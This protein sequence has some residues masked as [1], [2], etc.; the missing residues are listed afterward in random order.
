M[1]VSFLKKSIVWLL[2]VIAVFSFTACGKGEYDDGLVAVPL[3]ASDMKDRQYEDVVT[4]F[5]N[6]GFQNVHTSPMNDLIIGV[7]NKNGA[8]EEV[9]IDGKNNFRKNSRYEPDAYVVIKYHSFDEEESFVQDEESG[10]P[11]IADTSDGKISIPISSEDVGNLSVTDIVNIF[12]DAGFVDVTPQPM[13]DLIIGLVHGDGEVEEVSVDG[14]IVFNKG[15]RYIPG[16][17][18][19]IRYHS[20]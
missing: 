3:S 5:K 9:T 18:I 1:T 10:E 11:A 19:I 16:A 17:K 15:D 14:D 6:A 2:A 12:T 8:V 13:G 4:K 20:Y 7:F